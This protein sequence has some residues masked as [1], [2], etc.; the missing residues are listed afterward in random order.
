MLR[1]ERYG[2]PNRARLVVFSLLLAWHL[3]GHVDRASL[4]GTVT[5][6]SGAVIPGAKVAVEAPA[7]GFHRE[8]LT[9]SDGSY[10]LPGLPI[11]SYNITVAAPDL[12][13]KRTA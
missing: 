1:Y 3:V 8:T 11:G 9:K 5:D 6:V 12:R 10:N 7:T 2:M 13:W 4:N